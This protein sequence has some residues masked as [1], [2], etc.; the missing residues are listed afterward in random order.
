MLF[1]K[2]HAISSTSDKGAS[3]N[4]TET[5]LYCVNDEGNAKYLKL[6]S[7]LHRSNRI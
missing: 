3:I 5:S 7:N 6:F 4:K 2:L 1:E